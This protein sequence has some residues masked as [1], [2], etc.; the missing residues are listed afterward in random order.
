[1]IIDAEVD[2]QTV[3]KYNLTQAG[4]EVYSALLGEE[5]LHLA[6][7]RLPS[8]ILLDFTL[9]DISGPQICRTLKSDLRTANIPI[10][11]LTARGEETDRTAS[12]E[13]GADA[14]LIKPFS[15]RELVLQL[16]TISHRHF[17][18]PE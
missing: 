13:L 17:P 4:Y 12:A 14:Y 15:I 10:L 8:I 7:E 18:A 2:L 6:A 11:M 3:L 5:G 1:L 16:T 9:P